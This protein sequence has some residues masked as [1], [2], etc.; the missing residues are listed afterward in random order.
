[1][2]LDGGSGRIDSIW[3]VHS[4]SSQGDR[5]AVHD[6]FMAYVREA[7]ARQVSGSYSEQRPARDAWATAFE[8]RMEELGQLGARL[9]RLGGADRG[10]PV[11]GPELNS[12]RV[13]C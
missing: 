10:V 12:G 5:D 7:A 4:D 1:M 13:T 8:G 2:L 3:S 9:A 6:A 11:G